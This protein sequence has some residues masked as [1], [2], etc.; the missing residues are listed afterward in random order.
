MTED[1][2]LQKV[3]LAVWTSLDIK[4][5]LAPNVN[6]DTLDTELMLTKVLESLSVIKI[7]K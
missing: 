6:N 1:S 3:M 5:T 4:N 7:K 2:R